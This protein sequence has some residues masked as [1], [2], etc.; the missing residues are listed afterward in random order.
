MMRGNGIQAEA[1]PAQE[2]FLTRETVMLLDLDFKQQILDRLRRGVPQCPLPGKLAVQPRVFHDE[3]R[4]T[5][6]LHGA[7]CTQ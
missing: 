2:D 5:A 6:T 4:I 7:W 1:L 3:G